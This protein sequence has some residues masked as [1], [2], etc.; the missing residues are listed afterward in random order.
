MIAQS[1]Q[2][3][4]IEKLRTLLDDPETLTGIE[5]FVSKL[6]E[7]N[8]TVAP[9]AEILAGLLLVSGGFARVGGLLAAATMVVA[10]YAHV[11][12]DWADE[13]PVA[14]PLAVLAGALYVLV[15]GAGAFSLDAAAGAERTAAPT[16]ATSC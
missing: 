4:G 3:A 9:L 10:L 15:R 8:A 7:L 1:D 14:L 2:Q 11:V 6:P 12:A 16:P 13:P 5:Q